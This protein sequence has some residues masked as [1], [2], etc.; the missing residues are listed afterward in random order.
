MLQRYSNYLPSRD[1]LALQQIAYEFRQ[2]IQ[3][4]EAFE[5]Y[6]QWYYEQAK[7]HQAEYAQMKHDI[8]L[9]DRL[10]RHKS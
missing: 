3:Y 10:N 8:P 4:R 2:E 7:Q 1:P 9:L 6:C 5:A